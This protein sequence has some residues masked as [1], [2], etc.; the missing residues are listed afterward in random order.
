MLPRT[1]SLIALGITMLLAAIGRPD[2]LRATAI[3]VPP[4]AAGLE[5]GLWETG[6]TVSVLDIPGLPKALVEKMARD[7]NASEVRRKCLSASESAQPPAGMFQRLGG[8]CHYTSW[9]MAEGQI[10]AT[11]ACT[12]PGKTPG[13]ASMTLA[14]SY[15][16]NSFDLVS[17]VDARDGEGALQMHMIS[18]LSGKRAGNCP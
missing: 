15:T 12:P 13:Q 11:L 17:T 9:R 5:P 14:G 10:T 3:D 8:E 1:Y 6:A 2:A 7:P 16:G 18:R 4:P